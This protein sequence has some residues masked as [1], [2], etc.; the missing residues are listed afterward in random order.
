MVEKVSPL[1]KKDI[2]SHC[3]RRDKTDRHDVVD[4]NKVVAALALAKKIIKEH[5]KYG[6]VIVRK[7]EEVVQLTLDECFQ[8]GEEK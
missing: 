4:L 3:I 2:E 6:T 7:F 1:T 5:S 8:I